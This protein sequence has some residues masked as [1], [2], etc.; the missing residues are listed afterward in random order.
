MWSAQVFGSVDKM[1]VLSDFSLICPAVTLKDSAVHWC[2]QI[3]GLGIEIWLVEF[4]YPKHEKSERYDRSFRE[5]ASHRGV[6]NLWEVDSIFSVSPAELSSMKILAE[7]LRIGTCTVFT[8][9]SS[10]MYRH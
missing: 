1:A 8:R 7:E 10:G 5:A 9:S 2:L 4:C 3:S 6:G